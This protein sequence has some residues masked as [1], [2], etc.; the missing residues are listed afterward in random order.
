MVPGITPRPG[1]RSST[2]TSGG[3]TGWASSPVTTGQP[4]GGTRRSSSPPTT[5][6]SAWTAKRSECGRLE[7]LGELAQ[8]RGLGPR[9]DHL[10]DH[11]AAAEQVHGRHVQD[12]VS[13]CR[14][15]ILVDVELHHI[16]L[17]VVLGRDRFEHRADH[18][19]RAAPLRP[20]L[21]D[22]RPGPAEHVG[23][24]GL[25]GHDLGG[26]DMAPSLAALVALATSWAALATRSGLAS[27]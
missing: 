25:V 20:V 19:A 5:C 9:A 3:C 22:D 12:A 13:L 18:P 1:T 4:N 7:E 16:D 27:A 17:A 15:G 6:C 21:H 2:A 10:L 11:L 8:Q 23:L 24:E 14:L 26:H